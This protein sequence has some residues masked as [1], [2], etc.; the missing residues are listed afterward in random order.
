MKTL[1]INEKLQKKEWI[2]LLNFQYLTYLLPKRTKLSIKVM[3]IIVI[4]S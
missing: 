3:Q 4:L 1:E 2:Y